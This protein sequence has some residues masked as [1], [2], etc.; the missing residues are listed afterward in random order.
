[1]TP[2]EL[3]TTRLKAR[4]VASGADIPVESLLLQALAGEKKS[5]ASSGITLN[6]HISGQLHEPL[7]LYTFKVTARLVAAIDDDKTGDLFK[8]NYDAL[9]A[10]FDFLARG[11]NCTELGDED[12]T[13][14]GDTPDGDEPV[15]HI[16]A[17]DGF[18]LADG[19]EPDYQA[20]ENGGTWVTTFTATLTGR[21]N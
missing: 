10:A 18:Q 13:P 16:F 12:D 1:M 11:D 15:A 3:I 14:D 9:W 19:D 17:V 8:R 4:I 6:V 21:A 2:A 5:V 20:D 7:P